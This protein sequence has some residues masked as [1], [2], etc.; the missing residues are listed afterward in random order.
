VCVVKCGIHLFNGEAVVGIVVRIHL[1][2]TL[3]NQEA[4]PQEGPEYSLFIHR[5]V[6][7]VNDTNVPVECEG[8]PAWS[9]S[10]QLR[11]RS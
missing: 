10:R 7:V 5:Y 9:E 3:L 6:Y 11:E 8:K 4:P 2:N 1:K